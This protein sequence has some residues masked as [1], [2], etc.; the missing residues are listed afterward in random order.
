MEITKGTYFK[1]AIGIP[2]D[3]LMKTYSLS[4]IGLTT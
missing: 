2:I 4:S 3:E 1:S